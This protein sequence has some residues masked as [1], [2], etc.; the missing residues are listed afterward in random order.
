MKSSRPG[1]SNVCEK[2]PVALERG[3]HPALIQ[4][5]R[6]GALQDVLREEEEQLVAALVEAR[7]RN[8]DRPAERPRLVVERVV[9]AA[10]TAPSGRPR[11][12]ACR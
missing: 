11:T 7:A 5:A 12:A 10:C 2:S 3:R 6:I 9:A 4:A 1:V 8:Q